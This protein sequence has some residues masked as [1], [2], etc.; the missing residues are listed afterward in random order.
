V[1][2]GSSSVAFGSSCVAFQ[3]A[4]LTKSPPKAPKSRGPN[5]NLY[6]LEW[7]RH[8]TVA[9]FS[10]SCR[11]QDCMH[12]TITNSIINFVT[13]LYQNGFPRLSRRQSGM[14]GPG[15]QSCGI[16]EQL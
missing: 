7:T 9:E 13:N 10:G 2:L 12:V 11:M 6:I 5:E 1:A 4:V 14:D 3:Q 8:K 16:E 15:E